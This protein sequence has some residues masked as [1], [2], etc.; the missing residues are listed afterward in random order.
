VESFLEHVNLETLDGVAERYTFGELR[1][2]RLNTIY[3]LTS[4]SLHHFVRGYMSSST[5]YKAFFTTNFAWLLA[6]F[7]YMTVILSALQ[8]GLATT[9]LQISEAFQRGSYGFSF[10][11]IVA[12][13]ASVAAIFIVWAVL[14]VYHLLSTRNYYKAVVRKR[15]ILKENLSKRQKNFRGEA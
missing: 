8:V 9:K 6:V 2:S 15:A 13:L 4:L 7:A 1:L 5:W 3:R 14:F 12:V 10:A 11:C